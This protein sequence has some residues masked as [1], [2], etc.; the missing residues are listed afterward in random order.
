VF[1]PFRTVA[2][3]LT[4]ILLPPTCTLCGTLTAVPHGMCGDCWKKISFITAPY[5]PR[6]SL[7]QPFETISIS[8]S[9]APSLLDGGRAALL[10]DATCAR[11]LLPFKNSDATERA[12]LLATLL[13]QAAATEIQRCDV[14]MPIP[15]HGWR[16]LRRRYN[17][18]ALLAAAVSAQSGVPVLFTVLRR[19]KRT[20]VQHFQRRTARQRNLY[21]AFTT[22][23]PPHLVGKTIGVMDDVWTTG[24]TLNEA[25]R[26]LKAAGAKAVYGLTVARTPL[27]ND[28]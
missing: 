12:P 13:H 19:N 1:F 6:C 17:Q 8:C 20:K 14:L 4:N 27:R 7:P 11:L 3:V 10:Y 16:L 23:Y 25:A 22:R 15:L 18:A 2:R 26:V 9:C 21:G 28:R 5:C 24:A